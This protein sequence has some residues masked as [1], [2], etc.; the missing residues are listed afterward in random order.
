MYN[1]ILQEIALSGYEIVRTIVRQN[2][3]TLFK[4]H[5]SDKLEAG[6]SL[7]VW[8]TTNNQ[9]QESSGSIIMNAQDW[10]VGDIM[11]TVVLN[12][13]GQVCL[14]HMILY[15]YYLI[16]FILNCYN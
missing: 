5:R 11:V 15:I 8:S 14:L 12:A 7:T 16:S 13:E 3:S 4:F 9:L 2:S 10:V 6:E 1:T